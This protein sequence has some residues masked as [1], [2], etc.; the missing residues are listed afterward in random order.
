MR[1]AVVGSGYVGLVSGACLADFGHEV[2]CIDSDAA[3]IGAL[4]A[5]IMPLYEPGLDQIVAK[6]RA[7]NRPVFT[8]DLKAGVSDAEAI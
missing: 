7:A 6:N 5:G 1:I 2:T 4:K 8:T 3:K